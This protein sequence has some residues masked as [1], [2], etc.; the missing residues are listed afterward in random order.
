MV[1]KYRHYLRLKILGVQGIIVK[2]SENQVRPPLAES[3]IPLSMGT[4]LQYAERLKTVTS[5]IPNLNI[6]DR[7]LFTWKILS[8]NLTSVMVTAGLFVLD[9]E[10]NE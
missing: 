1:L 6:H 9:G 7:T 2:S 5:N 3:S 10:K 8:Q 4:F